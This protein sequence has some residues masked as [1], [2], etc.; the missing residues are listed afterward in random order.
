MLSS[1]GQVYTQHIAMFFADSICSLAQISNLFF[2]FLCRLKGPSE[3]YIVP[4][5]QEPRSLNSIMSLHF[6]SL[7]QPDKSF[8]AAEGTCEAY[9]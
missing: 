3:A 6:S 9:E 5:A 4:K 1:R 7:F 2:S 8:F